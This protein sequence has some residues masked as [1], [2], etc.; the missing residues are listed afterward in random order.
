MNYLISMALLVAI[1]SLRFLRHQLT[2]MAS[3]VPKRLK[4]IFK[5]KKILISFN[6]EMEIKHHAGD[7][8][9]ED[10]QTHGLIGVV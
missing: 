10:E 1:F 9:D 6:G 3:K 2:S 7:E 5:F 8:H 4:F